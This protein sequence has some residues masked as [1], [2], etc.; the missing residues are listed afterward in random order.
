M[1]DDP[2]GGDEAAGDHLQDGDR[3]HG[4]A[5]GDPGDTAGAGQRLLL[6]VQPTNLRPLPHPFHPL[7]GWSQSIIFSLSIDLHELIVT[8]HHCN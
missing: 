5:R 2:V 6:L 8:I 3:H 7:P 1:A 4:A